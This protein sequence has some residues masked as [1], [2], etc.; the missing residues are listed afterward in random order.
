MLKTRGLGFE[1]PLHG[2]GGIGLPLD[3]GGVVRE[4]VEAVVPPIFLF[5]KKKK[6]HSNYFKYIRFSKVVGTSP[7]I[8]PHLLKTYF[9]S[10]KIK[11]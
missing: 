2:Q 9:K 11:L 7:L 6:L 4:G 3:P 8:T 10:G 5:E 1:P